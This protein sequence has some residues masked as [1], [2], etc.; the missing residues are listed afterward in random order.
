MA[1]QYHTTYYNLINLLYIQYSLRNI[2]NYWSTFKIDSNLFYYFQKS[3]Y[4]NINMILHT[5]IIIIK[6]I[7]IHLISAYNRIFRSSIVLSL[8]YDLITPHQL[9]YSQTPPIITLFHFIIFF[10]LS[11][12]SIV[13]D[14]RIG[15]RFIL[16]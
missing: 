1:T 16:N 7:L 10:K 13:I 15:H 14:I 5:V 8:N 11:F 4:R 2:N 12:D 6:Q 9:H 3:Q